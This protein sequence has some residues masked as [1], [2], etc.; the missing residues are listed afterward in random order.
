[1]PSTPVRVAAPTPVRV[2]A[3]GDLH[4]TKASAGVFQPL[5]A[6]VAESAE[7]LLI[8]GDLTDYGLPEEARILVKE[9]STVH[10]PIVA[11]LGNHDF[12][13]GKEDELRQILADGGVTLLD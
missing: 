8:A 12:E 13:S 9:L 3:L 1:M 7:I 5:F 10:V 6:R 4:C 2:A 11:V